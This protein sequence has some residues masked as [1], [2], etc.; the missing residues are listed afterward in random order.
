M[1]EELR[2]APPPEGCEQTPA[3]RWTGRAELRLR[4]DRH[5]TGGWLLPRNRLVLLGADWEIAQTGLERHCVQ[6]EPAPDLSGRTT[7]RTARVVRDFATRGRFAAA[8]PPFAGFL[9]LPEEPALSPS[10]RVL[11]A[12]PPSPDKFR[13][14]QYELAP[15][16]PC[17]GLEAAGTRDE[18]GVQL[19]APQLVSCR[20]ETPL[21]QRFAPGRTTAEDAQSCPDEPRFA[22]E[23]GA[24]LSGQRACEST[25][26]DGS[27]SRLAA[28]WDLRRVPCA[29]PAED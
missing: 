20:F 15:P 8:E 23:E 14:G 17:A 7:R 1:E 26:R 28:E 11:P 9:Y 27:A 10:G 13:P 24:R 3:I 4:E 21:L 16:T 5:E 12:P 18:E 2:L 29:A 19:P 22:L 25:A 6:P